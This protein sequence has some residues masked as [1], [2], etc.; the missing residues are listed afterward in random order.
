MT[1]KTKLK[2]TIIALDFGLEYGP[3]EHINRNKPDY[4][5]ELNNCR[6]NANSGKVLTQARISLKCEIPIEGYSIKEMQAK[7][8]RIK[9]DEHLSVFLGKAVAMQNYMNE[10]YPDAYKEIA[11]E[12]PGISISWIEKTV[13]HK[14]HLYYYGLCSKSLKNFEHEELMFLGLLEDLVDLQ[15][16][17]CP[18]LVTKLNLNL[19]FECWGYYLKDGVAAT[20]QNYFEFI[21]HRKNQLLKFI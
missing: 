4:V 3:L 21:K 9:D 2:P 6:M 16:D 11:K 14:T 1:K 8:N 18:D 17:E 7:C 19:H 20:K 15:Q 13:F 10:K 12:F 5:L